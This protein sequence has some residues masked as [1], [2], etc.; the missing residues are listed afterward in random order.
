MLDKLRIICYY[1]D[2][3]RETPHKIKEIKIM[4][5][6]HYYVINKETNKATNVGWNRAKAEEIIAA[7]ADP[8][9]WVI[10]YKWRSI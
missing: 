3:K 9:N 5:L 7:K 2:R 10:G 1:I 4:R 8:E 6:I